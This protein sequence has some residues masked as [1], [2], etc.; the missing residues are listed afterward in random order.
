[1]MRMTRLATVGVLLA[2][3]STPGISRASAAEPFEVVMVAISAT[4]WAAIKFNNETGEAWT[5]REGEWVKI[6]DDEKLA[7][8][9]YTIRMTGLSND[10]SA[11]RF[12]SRTGRSWQCRDGKWVEIKD[13]VEATKVSV[14]EEQ[15]VDGEKP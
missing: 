11:I 14:S 9:T 1:M 3:L 13:R 12:D 8:G 2:M 6:T 15:P 10:W 7:E 5:A 4:T